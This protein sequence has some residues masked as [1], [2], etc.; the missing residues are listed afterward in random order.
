MGLMLSYK[1]YKDRYFDWNGQ[2]FQPY[3][4]KTISMWYKNIYNN[5]GQIIRREYYD[6]RWEEYTINNRGYLIEYI[7]SSG[8]WEQWEYD[9]NGKLINHKCNI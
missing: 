4:I 8:M 1:K 3:L 2:E 7:A 9:T 6:G 5:K